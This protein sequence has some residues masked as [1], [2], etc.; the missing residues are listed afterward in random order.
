MC[1]SKWLV[2]L[3]ALFAMRG[4]VRSEERLIEEMPVSDLVFT[5]QKGELQLTFG[6]WF[7]RASRWEAPV[8]LE[9]GLTSAW[10]VELTAGGVL[11][12]SRSEGEL[13]ELG[14]RRSFLHLRGTGNHVAL[15]LSAEVEREG[16]EERGRMSWKPGAAFARD[17]RSW[18]GQVFAGVEWSGTR[19]LRPST[20]SSGP[21]GRT[22][23][24][25]RSSSH[26]SSRGGRPIG[27]PPGGTQRFNGRQG[28]CGGWL[29]NLC[30]NSRLPC[31]SAS[32]DVRTGSALG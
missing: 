24:G 26:T 23:G 18:Q 17:L 12:G 2:G 8:S 32:R 10:E 15:G 3:V 21:Q 28:W 13:L 27:S 11:H 29:G 25:D 22:S 9:Y 20:V 5:Q 31:R 6:S 7:P 19:V 1:Q 14:V 4:P 16:E 30:G